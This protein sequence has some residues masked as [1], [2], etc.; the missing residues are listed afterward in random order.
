M[1]AA[2]YAPGL[3][4]Y[5]AGARKLGG[6]GD[7]VTA[8]E[9]SAL[10]GGCVARTCAEVLGAVGGEILEIGAGTG[11][12][13]CDL[14]LRLESLGALPARYRILEVSAD[15]KDRQ[16]Q[17]LGARAPHLLGRVS[18]LD[19]PPSSPFRGVIVGNEVLDALPVTRFRRHAG[20]YEELGVVVVDGAFAWGARPAD[21][22]LAAE[23]A[24]R[25]SAA[26][27]WPDGYASELC[28]R[29][30]AWTAAVTRALEAGAVLWFDYGLPRAQYYLPERDDGTLICHFRHRAHADP[31]SYPGLNDI[32]AW[33]DFSALA[34]AGSHAGF[35]VAGFA[36]QAFYLA[37]AGIESEMRA[38]GEAGPA[39]AA[40]A[41]HEARRLMLPGEM[42]ERF[43]AM[44][45][46]RGGVPP[47]GGFSLQDLRHSL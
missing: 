41:A 29:L 13:A 8:P 28:R 44:A 10:F 40:R 15:L 16:R 20:G 18:W 30:P 17:A 11:R 39:A 33:V 31:F 34:E 4:Y 12:L 46:C 38:A 42:G 43:K 35:E 25:E 2:L 23:C 24:R 1:D 7:F 26:G 9:I 21:P 6:D 32:T 3:G 22:G 14:L 45:W 37:G 5:S 27:G 19:E 47:L 36:T